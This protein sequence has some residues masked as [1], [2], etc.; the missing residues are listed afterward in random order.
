MFKGIK[1]QIVLVTFVVVFGFLFASFQLYQN[2]ILPDKIS[3]DVSTVKFVKMVTISTDSNGYIMKVRLGEVENLME[4]YKEIENKVN[5]YPVKINILLIDNPNEKL[6][7]VYYNSQFSI[8]EGIQ[9]GDYMKMYD[10]IREVSSKN[11]VKAFV[12]IDKQNIYLNLRDG[13][14]YLYKI[15]PREAYKGES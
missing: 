3:K 7:N 14:H 13:S 8:Y 4:T 11:G 15:I 2:K 5:K 1:W 12:Y 9:K 10:T 6:N